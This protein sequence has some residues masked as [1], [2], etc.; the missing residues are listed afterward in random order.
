MTESLNA[1]LEASL[2]GTRKSIRQVCEELGIEI[3]AYIN[4]EQCS[5]C[6]VWAKKLKVDLDGYPI[7]DVCITFYG[8]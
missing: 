8:E 7:C 5:H 6:S 1:E 3:P 2:K 4:L